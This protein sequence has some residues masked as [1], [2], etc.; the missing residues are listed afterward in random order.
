LLP[1]Q[2]AACFEEVIAADHDNYNLPRTDLLHLYSY[3]YISGLIREYMRYVED[4]I[5]HCYKDPTFVRAM[6]EHIVAE[7]W[8]SMAVV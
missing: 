4:A 3:C 1:Q 8:A 5:A 7:K 6:A 2:A